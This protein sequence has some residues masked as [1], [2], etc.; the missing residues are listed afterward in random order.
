MNP[1]PTP[2]TIPPD[3]LS[4]G[5][6]VLTTLSH[7]TLPAGSP[8][9]IDFVSFPFATCTWYHPTSRIP[10]VLVDLR[11]LPL[12]RTTPEYAQAHSPNPNP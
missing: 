5:D 9:R 3:D 6:F 4:P 1:H 8:L 2:R 7:P 12:A 10:G 11:L